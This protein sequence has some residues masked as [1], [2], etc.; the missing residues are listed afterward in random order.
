MVMFHDGEIEAQTRAGVR[1]VAARMDGFIHPGIAP[2]A[3]EFLAAQP[4]IIVATQR[5][6][7]TVHASALTGKP[8]FTRATAATS[9]EIHPAGGHLDTVLGDLAESDLLGMLAI[10]FATKRR[11]RANGRASVRNGV[12]TLSTAEVY[13]NCPQYIDRRN[14]PIEIAAGRE[15]SRQLTDAQ[16]RWIESAT[17]FFI[18]SVVPEHGADA[19][20]RGGEPG[21][22]RVAGNTISWPDYAGNNMFNTIGNLLVQP[23]CGLLFIDFESGATLQI[24]GMASVQWEGERRIVVRT[25]GG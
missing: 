7:G 5:R 10:E 15:S 12:I 23:K 6:D 20:H 14:E 21:F 16:Q 19:S 22:V 25:S 11:M 13:S 17:T 8:G 1:D 2:R 9:I 4:M 3:A 24:E 18:A